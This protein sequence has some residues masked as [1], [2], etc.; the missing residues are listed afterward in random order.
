MKYSR[1]L[2]TSLAAII[3]L[4]DA[5]MVC[6]AQAQAPSKTVQA[7]AAAGADLNGIW[8]A[9]GTA[10]WDIQDHSAQPGPAQFGA[11]FAQPPG[12]GIVE[13]DEI[14]Y[15]PEAV[16]RKKEN[17]EN[18]FTADPEAKCYLPGVPRANYLPYPFQIV[19]SPKDILV[20]YEFAGAARTIHMNKP[21]PNP[22]DVAL[23]SWM[24]Y[25]SGHWEGRTLVVEASNFNDQTWFDR[26][27]NYHSDALKVTERY[28]PDGPNHI[29]YQA[30]IEDPKVFT[31][32]WRINLELYR[33]REKNAALLD[34]KCVEFSEDLLY[35][36]LYKKK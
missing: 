33:V 28:T 25:S 26:A 35:G 19:Q 9:L 14:P 22:V 30:T 1:L 36:D 11:L 31:R 34:F 4:L 32:P 13:G 8:M 23:D 16:A 24:G 6:A 18:R 20:A 10:N 5:R 3:G 15:K 17:Y 27:G 12:Q 7:S 2:S 29:A 21:K